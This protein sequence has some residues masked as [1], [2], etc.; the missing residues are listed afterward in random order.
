MLK[1]KLVNETALH[2]LWLMAMLAG[3]F[4]LASA[5]RAAMRVHP[6]EWLGGEGRTMSLEDAGER[7]W[8]QMRRDHLPLARIA[9]SGGSDAAPKWFAGNIA[10]VLG[11]STSEV[12]ARQLR[13]YLRWAR[14]VK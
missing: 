13:R 2:L 7:A 9:A 4:I 11:L 3:G 12:S 10:Q 5:L 8:Q 6:L 14:D 1:A